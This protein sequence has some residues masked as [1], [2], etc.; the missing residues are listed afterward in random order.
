M[1][2]IE[3]NVDDGGEREA[4]IV[5]YGRDE[6]RMNY[7]IACRPPVFVPEVHGYHSLHF[8]QK[9]MQVLRLPWAAKVYSML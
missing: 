2:E 3:Y 6:S 5:T 1:L 7:V 9:D 8:V 4:M